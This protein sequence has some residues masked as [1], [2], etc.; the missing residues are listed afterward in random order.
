M[1]TTPPKQ[2]PTTTFI[3]YYSPLDGD[4]TPPKQPHATT[5]RIAWAMLVISLI[6]GF[7]MTAFAPT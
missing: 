7:G 4:P 1:D 6:V 3:S 2:P 5:E